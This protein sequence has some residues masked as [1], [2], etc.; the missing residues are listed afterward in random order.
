M[1]IK[2]LFSLLL[3]PLSLLSSEK[4]ESATT[5]YDFYTDN[6]GTTINSPVLNIKQKIAKVF[7]DF[8]QRIDAITSA[9]IRNSAAPAR[10]DAITGASAHHGFDDLR[11]ASTL[12]G[13]YEEDEKTYT[14]GGYFSSEKDYLGRAI[15]MSYGENFNLENTHAQVAFSSSS[16]LW[17]PSIDRELNRYDRK[18]HELTLSL[19]QVI[20]P[21]HLIGLGYSISKSEGFL[22]SPYL[23]LYGKNVT[24]FE[25]LPN[26]KLTAGFNLKGIHKLN[27]NNS[28]HWQYNYADND[29]EN[30][31]HTL[32]LNNYYHY[33]D[34]HLIGTH[35]RH[36]NQSGA[37]FEQD[38]DSYTNNSKYIMADYR[39]GTYS[40][41][42]L[43]ASDN[44]KLSDTLTLKSAINYYQTSEHI[45]I[46]RWNGTGSVQA[47][48]GSLS[49]TLV[50]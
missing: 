23:Y 32:A 33:D 28:L 15:F 9:S 20:T 12:S 42:T 30:S 34:K 26:S 48:F 31:A 16:D 22:G 14:L 19:T 2:P 49:L 4:K 46:K 7:V 11:N 43:G 50:R 29:W 27:A 21:N 18:N 45:L 40:T 37:F 17:D 1:Q 10:A 36:Y 44:F 24:S 5:S 8:T 25:R 47:F 3:L 39:Y 6:T 41:T 13:S 35:F 38:P